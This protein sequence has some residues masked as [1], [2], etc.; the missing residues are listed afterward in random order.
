MNVL[1]VDD[2]EGVRRSLRKVLERDRYIIFAAENGQEAI[3][4][5]RGNKRDIET[6]ISDF[7]MPGLN[8]LETL[9]EIGRLNP[10]IT[11]IILTGYATMES[12]IESVNAGIDGFLTK[13][14]DNEE[15]RAKVKEYNIKK[16]LKQ[17]VSEPILQELQRDVAEMYPKKHTVSVMFTDIRG[18]TGMAEGMNPKELS[19]LINYYYFAPLDQIIYEYRGTLD[20]HIGDGIMGIFGA[21][22][23]A[24]DDAGRAV[25]AALRMQEEIGAINRDLAEQGKKIAVGIGI[26]TGEA[27]A[28]IFGSPQKKE[29]TAFGLPVNIAARLE[30][31][32]LEGQILICEQTYERVQDLVTVE[33]MGSFALKGM[34]RRV[35]IFNITG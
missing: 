18:F 21:P 17:F 14:F 12:A 3:E 22:K 23:A 16:R 27:M 31:L 13:P 26:S 25:L 7:K 33:P 10:E 9:I 24:A 15:L 29:Y 6:V 32:A 8:G 4:I 28:G 30:H 2:E 11:R 35:D 20:K 5:V 1:I 34:Q 19:D